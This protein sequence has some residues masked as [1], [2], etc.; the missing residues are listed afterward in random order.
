MKLA[1]YEQWRKSELDVPIEYIYDFDF[2]QW[3]ST[4]LEFSINEVNRRS[5][6]LWDTLIPNKHT[7]DRVNKGLKKTYNRLVNIATIWWVLCMI[8][9]II[10]L[11]IK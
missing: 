1:T 7:K 5:A 3:Y 11:A 6:I 9:I 10:K 4:T 8:A 2:Y